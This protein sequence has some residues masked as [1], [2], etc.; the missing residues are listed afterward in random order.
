M[1][2]LAKAVLFGPKVLLIDEMSHGLAPLVSERL[3]TM[4]R[5]LAQR[6]GTAVLLVE[7]MVD[8][9]LAVSDR[10]YV[11]RQGRIVMDGPPAEVA[12]HRDLLEAHYLGTAGELSLRGPFQ[13]PLASVTASEPI[14][15]S[16]S[17]AAGSRSR[18][19]RPRSPTRPD[20]ARR[21]TRRRGGSPSTYPDFDPNGTP[22]G[23]WAVSS[24]SCWRPSIAVI[25]EVHPVRRACRSRR[26]TSARR[27]RGPS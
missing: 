25:H 19:C 16:A 9:A 22:S 4:V 15:L 11:M 13:W 12:E 1:V 2:A 20:P 6:H 23:T 10:A 26:R 3:L 24:R 7:Q 27:G 5:E 18:G 14:A 21:R 8:M 17:S